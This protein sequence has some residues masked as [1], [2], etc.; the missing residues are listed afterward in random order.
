MILHNRQAS[1]SLNMAFVSV[2]MS[3]RV[4]WTLVV[5]LVFFTRSSAAPAFGDTDKAMVSTLSLQL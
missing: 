4:L 2:R 5:A 3:L 1:I